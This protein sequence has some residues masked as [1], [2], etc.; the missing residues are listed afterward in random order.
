MGWGVRVEIAGRKWFGGRWILSDGMHESKT[1]ANF[2]SAVG[3]LD[4]GRM[5]MC[6]RVC[7]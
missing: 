1:V 7:V 2:L 6:V 5:Y 3:Y 4:T